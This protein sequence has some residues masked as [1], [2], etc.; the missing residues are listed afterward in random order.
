MTRAVNVASSTLPTWTTAT[1]PASPVIGQQGVNTTTNAVEIYTGTLWQ[2]IIGLQ[3][4]VEYVVVAG[5]GSGNNGGG[6]AGGYRSSVTGESSGGGT[7]AESVIT[8][9]PGTAYTVTVGAGGSPNSNGSNSVF[10]SITSTGGGLSPYLNANGSAGGSGGGGGL[11]SSASGTFAGGA[12]TAGQGFA[13]GSSTR[14]N[15]N[16]SGGGGGGAGSVGSNGSPSTPGNAGSG[17]SSSI[18][19]TATTRAVG[20]R[21]YADPGGVFGTGTNVPAANTGSGGGAAPATGI[22]G[23]SGVVIIR[24][25][26]TQKGTGGTVTSSG[27][28]T[29]HTFT[30]SGTYTA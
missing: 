28:F 29:I 19:G 6:G 25:S 9:T 2:N 26:G 8:L 21:G 27:G 12:G 13:G 24:Y 14:T 22:A 7:P 30:T 1:R 15:P 3:Y 5:G 10:G 17:V 4:T 11:T 16:Y 20:G 23:G 18:D